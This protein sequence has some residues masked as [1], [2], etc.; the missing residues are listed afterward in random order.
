M[1][2]T[3]QAIKLKKHYGFQNRTKAINNVNLSIKHGEFVAIVGK[4]DSGKSTLFEL[5]GA[6]SVPTAGQVYV[7]GTCLADLSAQQLSDIRQ[8]KIGYVYQSFN[9]IPYLNV[10][11]NITMNKNVDAKYLNRVLDILKLNSKVYCL[12]DCLNSEEQQRVAIARSL[13]SKPKL[14]I[15]DEP[16]CNLDFNSEKQILTLLKQVNKSLNITVILFTFNCKI[17]N[18]AS[19]V[20]Y[21]KDGKLYNSN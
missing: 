12:P 4:S 13:I 16:T 19:R 10:W 14:L 3:L 5:F 9:L 15:A 1:S 7:D 11:N 17:A 18:Y 6:L 2:Y 8:E 21:L 20:L